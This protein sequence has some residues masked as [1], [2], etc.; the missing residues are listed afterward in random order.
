MTRLHLLLILSIALLITGCD[1]ESITQPGENDIGNQTGSVLTVG[2]SENDRGQVIIET[3]DG[4]TLIAGTTN[5][6]DRDFAGQ[7]FGNRDLFL[8]KIDLSGNIEWLNNYGGS[9]SDWAMDV[10]EDSGGNYVMTGYTR[11]DTDDFSGQNRGENDIFLIKIAPN[12]QP[13]FSRTYGGSDE[14]YGYAVTEAP[15]GGYLVAGASRST[16]GNFSGRGN[17]SLDIFL[18]RTDI[19]GE[20]TFMQAFG[21][22]QNDEAYDLTITQNNTVMI[23][24]R[25]N[26][27]DGDFS[28]GFIGDTGFFVIE[29]EL[30]GSP[31][32]LTTFGGTGT[33]VAESITA[34]DDGGVAIAGRTNSTDGHF[35]ERTD[36]STDAFLMKLNSG[37]NIEWVR[38]YGGSATD[39]ANAVIQL[40]TGDYMI[41]GESRSNDGDFENLNMGG[42]DAFTLLIQP[43]GT[44]DRVNIFGGSS[45]DVALSI[46]E[47]AGGNIAMTGWTESSDEIFESDSR[48][49]PDMFYL[50]SDIMGELQ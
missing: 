18:M 33:D 24:G 27:S 46:T 45:S 48:S 7:N 29:T 42:L 5:S 4:G 44:L 13:I 10:I 6:N 14:D 41:A 38:S 26:S 30:N 22:S 50:V 37:R 36:S 20:L 8:M 39:A 47:L 19:N 49:A 40:Q 15:N 28:G 35:E 25:F 11:S 16:D 32:G 3:S 12:G 1:V 43:D 2:G 21:G 23:T 9:N 17:D 31:R 34:T